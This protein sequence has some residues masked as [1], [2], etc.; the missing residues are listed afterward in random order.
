MM[1]VRRLLFIASLLL[2]GLSAAYAADHRHGPTGTYTDWNWPALPVNDDGKRYVLTSQSLH[3]S[4]AAMC[5]DLS[6][7]MAFAA[8]S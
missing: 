5:C 6:D 8:S 7:R 4:A 3:G 1:N 2:A